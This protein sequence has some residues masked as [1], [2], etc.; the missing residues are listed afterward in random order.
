MSHVSPMTTQNDTTQT[1]RITP[2]QEKEIILMISLK[3]CRNSKS[4]LERGDT[5]SKISWIL[6]NRPL[7]E[8]ELDCFG[9]DVVLTKESCKRMKKG[10]IE[11]CSYKITNEPEWSTV[12]QYFRDLVKPTKT[13]TMK[14]RKISQS[15]YHNITT[16]SYDGWMVVVRNH[17][18]YDRFTR[19][20]KGWSSWT[21]HKG[22]KITIGDNGIRDF[23][24]YLNT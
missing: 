11:R 6:E 10:I 16:Y 14:P 4:I 7:I 23:V 15:R 20:T 24:K 13:K 8:G 21:A 1:K 5:P 9:W 18:Q 22:S 19:K 3:W 12:L 17:R 2:Q